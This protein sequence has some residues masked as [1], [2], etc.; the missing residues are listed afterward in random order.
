M[1]LLLLPKLGIGNTAPFNNNFVV[2]K[3]GNPWSDGGGDTF[4]ITSGVQLGTGPVFP[5]S[6]TNVS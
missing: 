6:S 5:G 1:S 2:N 4:D 3:D